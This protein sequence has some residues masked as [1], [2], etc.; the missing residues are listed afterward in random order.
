V[1]IV[2]KQFPLAFHNNA[3][4]AAEAA[5]AAKEQGKFWEM[6]DKMFENAQ[7]LDRAAL[8]GYAKGLGLNVDK[9]KAALDSGKYKAQ[10]QKETAEGSSAGV[11]GTP[12]FVINGRLVVGAQ[13]FDEFKKLIDAELAKK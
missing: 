13:P 11:Q 9:F 5:L 8:E 10:V 3:Q 7:A 12:S 2:F 6:H 4:G 1:A